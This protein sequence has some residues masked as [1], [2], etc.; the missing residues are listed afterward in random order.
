MGDRSAEDM[1]QEKTQAIELVEA[2]KRYKHLKKE[3]FICRGI[4]NVRK[5]IPHHSGAHR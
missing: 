1:Y 5:Q 3:S 2:T 4:E